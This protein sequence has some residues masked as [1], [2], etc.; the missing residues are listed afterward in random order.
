MVAHTWKPCTPG[1]RIQVNIGSRY[2]VSFRSAC[3]PELHSETCLKVGGD[4]GE[5]VQ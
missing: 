2:I 4:A 3:S 1:R 5:I